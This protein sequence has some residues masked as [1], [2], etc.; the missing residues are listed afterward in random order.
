M[1][2][3]HLLA[4]IGQYALIKNN[5]NKIL[6]LERSRSKNWSLP[7]GRLNTDEDWDNALLR[8]VKE[9]TSLDC[10]NPRPFAVRILKDEYQTKYCV[11][12][13]VEIS[14]VEKLLISHE[15][16]AYKWIGLNDLNQMNIEDVQ[17]KEVLL[18]YFKSLTS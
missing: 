6:V 9:E 16:S 4:K 3:E 17:I 2:N 11:Y 18:N 8:E 12:F 5:E 10:E 15:H 14:N 13:S 1:E 7:G